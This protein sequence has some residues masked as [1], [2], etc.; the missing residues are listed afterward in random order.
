MQAVIEELDG[1]PVTFAIQ[2]NGTLL[3]R[4]PTE[5][6]ERFVGIGVSIDGREE[7]TDAVRGA[8]TFE[9]V[10]ENVRAIAP[11]AKVP[12]M[13]RMTI[14][15][16]NDLARDIDVLMDHFDAIYWQLDNDLG[17]RPH[18]AF[19]KRYIEAL[20]EVVDHWERRAKEGRLVNLVPF[21][22]VYW[23]LTEPPPRQIYYH[24]SPGGASLTIDATGRI[25]TCPEGV[26]RGREEVGGSDI[27]GHIESLDGELPVLVHDPK[28]ECTECSIHAVCG[29]RCIWTSRSPYCACTRALVDTV[30]RNAGRMWEYMDRAELRS[31]LDTILTTE[32]IP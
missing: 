13:A 20:P 4:L 18:E 11:I 14:T 10:T 30:R 24:C 12:I 31:M 32:I 21:F 5:L 29:G 6:I 15:E 28:Q 22:G 26:F 23:K 8:G 19:E 2:T 27:I 25:Y 9:K 16:K 1:H 3:D 17:D 7:V